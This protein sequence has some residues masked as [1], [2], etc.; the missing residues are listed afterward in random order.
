MTGVTPYK[1][2]QAQ[3]IED[4]RKRAIDA[5]KREGRAID[6]EYICAANVEMSSGACT[7]LFSKK[8]SPHYQ[9][10]FNSAGQITMVSGGNGSHGEGFWKREYKNGQPVGAASGSQPVRSE[11]NRTSS[12]A[13]SGG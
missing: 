6:G 3:S 1:P 10:S 5:V 12:T 7:L 2:G 13:G 4:V 8:W 9:V 11:T